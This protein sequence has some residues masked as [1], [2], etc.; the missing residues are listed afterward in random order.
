MAKEWLDQ[1]IHRIT[2][3]RR[4]ALR[5]AFDRSLQRI[6]QFP[7]SGQRC[8]VR[9]AELNGLADSYRVLRIQD[10]ILIYFID[11]TER[12][13]VLV[14][15]QTTAMGTPTPEMLSQ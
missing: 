1:R 11:E 9:F 15:H 12:M 6:A 10:L 13:I 3:A 7:F 4:R 14:R 5:F 8:N 2:P